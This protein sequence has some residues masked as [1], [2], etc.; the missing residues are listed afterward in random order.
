MLLNGAVLK[1]R[2]LNEM[3]IELMRRHASTHERIHNLNWSRNGDRSNGYNQG[4]GGYNQ[5]QGGYNQGQGGGHLRSYP[6]APTPGVPPSNVAAASWYQQTTTNFSLQNTGG[7]VSGVLR[8][9][10]LQ[11]QFGSVSGASGGELRGYY[12]QSSG[13]GGYYNQGGSGQQ[14]Y[15]DR[16]YDQ[17]GQ[18]RGGYGQDRG[19]YNQSRGYGM[20]GRGSGYYQNQDARY[21]GTGSGYRDNRRR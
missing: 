2:V 14:G 3:D 10:D 4:Q 6:A 9:E 21:S 15:G 7:H 8:L 19:G 13:R 20:N 16:G 17:G 18:S 1:S 12:S 11:A 5:G